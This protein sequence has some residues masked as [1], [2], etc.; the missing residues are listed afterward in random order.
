[1]RMLYFRLSR[2][3]ISMSWRHRFQSST[4]GKNGL[5]NR[6]YQWLIISITQNVGEYTEWHMAH[7]HILSYHLLVTLFKIYCVN[8]V[9]NIIIINMYITSSRTKKS[10]ATVWQSMF[11]CV[12]TLVI[13]S[14]IFF[15]NLLYFFIYSYGLIVS[16]KAIIQSMI[17]SI[18]TQKPCN[19]P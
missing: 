15:F 9:P 3:T 14:Y 13:V 16:R 19:V 8:L 7:L 10:L 11:C 6:L 4:S 2:T 18:R 5:D 12:I 1:M 17:K